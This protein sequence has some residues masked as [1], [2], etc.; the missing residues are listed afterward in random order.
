MKKSFKIYQMHIEN[1]AKFMSLDFVKEN[2]LPLALSDYEKVYKGEAEV[3]EGKSNEIVCDHIYMKFQGAKPEGYKGHSI[4]MSDIIELDGKY[5]YCDSYGWEEITFNNKKD[6]TMK[7]T[8]K[9]VAMTTDEKVFNLCVESAKQSKNGYTFN[10]KDVWQAARKKY[11]MAKQNVLGAFDIIIKEHEIQKVGEGPSELFAIVELMPKE[12]KVELTPIMKQYIDLKA[13]H[14]DA[15]LLFRCGDFYETYKEDAEKISKILGITLTKS[16][17]TKDE[18]GKPLV[19]AGFPYHAIDTYLPKLIRAGQR[20]AIC[21]QLEAPKQTAKR[22]ISELVSPGTAAEKQ[23]SFHRQTKVEGTGAT[24]PKSTEKP[25][26]E[27][28]HVLT[29]CEVINLKAQKLARQLYAEF[30]RFTFARFDATTNKEYKNADDAIR[31][32][33]DMN[34]LLYVIKVVE[35]V[36]YTGK[37]RIEAYQ[38]FLNAA[39]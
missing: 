8:E 19:M 16:S 4:S 34:N 25:S 18:Q 32:K 7:Q 24:S 37:T 23:Q 27:P 5:Y 28:K 26:K 33:A 10:L 1:N 13:K 22:G 15:L 11:K 14:P 12:K 30:K 38:N 39:A 17:K 36:Q 6:T 29:E 2:N 9:K 20:V 35:G 31:G 3:P 21:D